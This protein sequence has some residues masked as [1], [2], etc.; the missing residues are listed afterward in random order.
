MANSTIRG[1]STMINAIV[2]TDVG[3]IITLTGMP[4]WLPPDDVKMIV[5]GHVENLDQYGW[6]LTFN[7][8][9]ESPYEVGVYG[10]AGSGSMR[11]DAENST[12]TALINN[13]VTSFTVTSAA[14]TALWTI[15]GAE[16]PFDI[17]IDGERMTVTAITGASSPQ[18]FTVTR[19]VNGA[20]KGHHTGAAVHLWTIFRYAL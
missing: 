18:T 10:T 1:S 11:Y 16:F 4:A 2:G 9:P 6:D 5:Q 13:S 17:N 14:N 15:A 12:L 19:G 7:C 20:A 8:A 3:E